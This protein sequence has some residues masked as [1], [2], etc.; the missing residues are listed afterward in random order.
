MP[1]IVSA[2]KL[3]LLQGGM[4]L[5]VAV[6]LPIGKVTSK[7]AFILM[8]ENFSPGVNCC[9]FPEENLENFTCIKLKLF[10]N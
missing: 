3:R 2:F 9:S 1:F 5:G 8:K 4:L 6:F 10:L 7:L